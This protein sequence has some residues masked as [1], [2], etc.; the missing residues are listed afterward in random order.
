MENNDLRLKKH[1]K[2][3]NFLISDSVNDNPISMLIQDVLL[4]SGEWFHFNTIN[5]YKFKGR[6]YIGFKNANSH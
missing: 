6:N 3:L 4:H 5:K 2:L 1:D